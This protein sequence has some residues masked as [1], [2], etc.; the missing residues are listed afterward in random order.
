MN[1]IY[2][3]P[4]NHHSK[5]QQMA[6]GILFIY[7]ILWLL[8]VMP[9]MPLDPLCDCRQLGPNCWPQNLIFQLI[10]S[11]KQLLQFFCDLIK[12]GR[13]QSGFGLGKF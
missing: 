2:S 1:K 5:W 4:Q 10:N 9:A 11:G 7:L 13:F 12:D 6:T 3:I 8:F